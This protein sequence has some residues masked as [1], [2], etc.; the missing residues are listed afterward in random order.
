MNWKAIAL[1]TI[2][3]SS[4]ILSYIDSAADK[5][6]SKDAGKKAIS[7]RSETTR[8]ELNDA[9]KTIDL[10]DEVSKRERKEINDQLNKW[11]KVNDYDD[12]L[13]SIHQKAVDELSEFKASINY[14][15]RKQDI[16]DEAEDAIEAFKESIDYDYEIDEL[17]EEIED[18]KSLYKKH[19]KLYDI[20]GGGDDDVSDAVG[21]LKK[22]EKEKMDSAVKK[23]NEK[24]S[25]L[26]AK[27]SAEKSKIDR[28]KQS[29]LRE[30]E[31]EL[32]S[33]K[34]RINKTETEE[35]GLVKKEFEAAETQIREGVFAKRTQEEIAA[36]ENYFM[37]KERLS[38]Q[39]EI[40]A[41]RAREFYT[42]TP[43]HEKWA[44]WLNENKCPKWFAVTVG[45]LPLVPAGY[46]ISSYV[47]FLYRTVKAM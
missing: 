23:A 46:L 21:E 34:T 15:D 44:A 39:K 3:I 20:A 32:Q 8:R 18:A 37:S 6:L 29:E 40:D 47:G 1:G 19:C 17:E 22:S 30:L 36:Q 5:Q 45:V 42:N 14:Y 4:I 11:K 24:I 43:K 26:K 33:T 38:R 28:K 13:R 16:E 10:A 41:E 12:R 9:Q 7:D 27:V 2:G 31:Q 25:E 35:T